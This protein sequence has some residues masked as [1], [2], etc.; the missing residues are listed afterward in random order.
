MQNNIKM[1]VIFAGHGSPMLALED[2]EV[3]RG[4][5]KIGEE[6]IAEYGKPKAVLAISAYWYTRGTYV[7]KTENPKQVYD[8]YGFPQELYDFRYPAKGDPHLSDRVLSLLKDQVKVNNDWGIDHGTWT[9]ICHVFPEADIPVVQLSVDGTISNEEKYEMGKKLSVLREEG[10]LIF[11]SGNVV[12]NL[13]R[14][15]WN[16]PHGS[17]ETDVFNEAVIGLVNERNDQGVMNYKSLPHW[18][19]AVPTPD[20]FD[21]LFYILGASK[22]EK[23]LVFNNHSELGSISMTG[24]AFG[25]E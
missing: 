5:H 18:Q 7:Q 15:D 16:N 3:T 25:L 14:V 24:F 12:H 4:L 11:A 13:R 10:Y 6:I 17:K 23:P 19:Y 9:V 20:H 8:M 2:T 1:P 22:E 21:P